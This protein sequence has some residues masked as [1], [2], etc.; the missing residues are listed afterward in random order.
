MERKL[1]FGEKSFHPPIRRVPCLLLKIGGRDFNCPVL[2]SYDVPHKPTHKN[3][4]IL[5]V[6]KPRLITTVAMIPRT[7]LETAP[8][9]ELPW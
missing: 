6:E 9:V 8:E 1:F 2:A 3:C 5:V 7:D 4:I